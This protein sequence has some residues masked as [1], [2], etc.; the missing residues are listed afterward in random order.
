MIYH[1]NKSFIIFHLS[2]KVED[3]TRKMSHA[4]QA[5]ES[6]STLVDS[7]H[8]KRGTAIVV[9]S[10]VYSRLTRRVLCDRLFAIAGKAR[11]G[12]ASQ[13]VWL[14]FAELSTANG[15]LSLSPDIRALVDA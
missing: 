3:L 12:G 5:M 10:T 1:P 14:A 8:A 11:Y 2:R 4:F 13:A 15:M 7:P 9:R 6:M